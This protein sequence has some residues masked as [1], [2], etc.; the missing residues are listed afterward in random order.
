MKLWVGIVC[1]VSAAWAGDTSAARIQEAAT[2]AVASIQK[3]QKNW[4]TKQ[5]CFSCHQQVLPALAFRF[6]R[7]HGIAVDEPAAHADAAAAFGYYSNFERA[8]EYTYIIDP[9]MDDGYAM[10][11][12][13]AA[14]M[15]PSLVTAVY[16]R[17]LAARQEADGHWETVDERPPQSYSL[18]TATAIALRA[19]QLYGHSSQ[20]VDIQARA[21]RA[22][23]WLLSHQPDATEERVYQLLGA[24]WAGADQATLK[25]LGFAN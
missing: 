8:V 25:K 19:I 3:S 2:K 4:Y 6:A 10:L 17:L 9:A 5:S 20:K 21:E 23:S 11:A 14:G 15:R 12:A 13:N 22:R 7:E 1:S 24:S 18:F 16:A